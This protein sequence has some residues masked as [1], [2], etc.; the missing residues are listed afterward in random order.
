VLKDVRVHGAIT[1]AIDYYAT[2]AGAKLL[3]APFY[4]IQETEGLRTVSFFLAGQYF[5]LD[6]QGI[7]FSGTG[8]SVSEYM[9]GSP[10][11]LHDLGHK[12]VRNRLVLFGAFTGGNGL[13]FTPQV[14]GFQP[15]ETLFL[16]GN[17]L[18]NAFFLI[19]VPWPYSVRRTQEVLLRTLG[20]VLKRSEKPG[21]GD[22]SGLIGEI[23]RELAEPEAT[24]LLLRLVH[25]PNQRFYEFVRGH[26]RRV[27]EWGE[28]QERFVAPLAEEMGIVG[29]QRERIAVDILYKDDAN[30]QVVDEYKDVLLRILQGDG[31]PSALA[32][33]NSLRNL[34]LR[35]GLPRSLFDT[36]D[37]LIPAA[38]VVRA[39]EP[40]YLRK[41]REI[42][43]GLFLSSRP[44]SEVVG[45]PEIARLLACKQMAQR[46]RDNGFEQILL[47]TGRAL[48]ERA[49]QGEDLEPLEV[50]SQ[51]VTYFDRL[52]NAEAMVSELAFMEHAT[53]SENK[54]RSLLGNRRHLE[55]VEEGLFHR[56]VVE[57][58]LQNPYILRL[59]R[60]K[61]A[62]LSDGLAA[63]ERGEK[64]LQ[65][66]AAGLEA[67]S[68][69]EAAEHHLY[70]S[71]RS[72]LKQ[73][74][75]DLAN[76]VHVRLLQREV[77]GELKK[78]EAWRGPVPEGAF[79]SALEDLKRESDYLN[80]VFPRIL[81][82]GEDSLREEF[83]KTS[84]LDRFRVEE[85]EREYRQ[86][87]GLAEAGPPAADWRADL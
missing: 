68:Q 51:V 62:A 75:F 54:V 70:L 19:K 53:V 12:E 42:F 32:R 26:Y 28:A 14:S 50:F 76:P 46:N 25:R 5:R 9:F 52:D 2:L 33:L 10:M 87:H 60:Q 47:D 86:A 61:V 16:D 3:S 23:L 73:F 64:N 17:A 81:E 15:Y 59:G 72:R 45:P 66:V 84:G 39:T 79:A 44:A 20:R 49:A 36:L 58:A 43:E 29:Y 67:L 85:L 63:V 30:R 74:Y 55:T 69:R 83:L 82:S 35:H 31:D 1:E 21:A 77:E 8:G 6:H 56:L 71:I 22:D 40:E 41:T 13:A 37:G 7:S 38:P 80:N 48:D 24:L 4:E 18:S 65:E 34:A 78:R 57:P 27:R 11:P